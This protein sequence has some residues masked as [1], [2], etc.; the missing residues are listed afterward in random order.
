MQGRLVHHDTI[1]CMDNEK[2]I[3][4]ILFYHGEPMRLSTLANI[5]T[6]KEGDLAV[7]IMALSDSLLQR[8]IRVVQENGYV[9][10]ATAPETH[11]IIEGMRREELDGPLGKAGLETLAII[12]YHG[13]LSK[14]D[15]EYIRGVNSSS[16]LRTLLIRGLVEKT[17]HPK[18]KRSFLYQGTPELP[19]SLGLSTLRDAPEFE[20]IKADVQKVLDE[21]ETNEEHE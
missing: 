17:P 13:P 21:Q 9:G 18:D 11:E 12:I 15:I 8:G 14:S 7:H 2:K 4:A 10:L 3:E 6:I 19:A 1:K 16:I 20:Q 5:L